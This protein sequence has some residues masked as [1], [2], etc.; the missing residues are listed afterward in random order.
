MDTKA[1]HERALRARRIERFTYGRWPADP[2]KMTK[3]LKELVA[4]A[5]TPQDHVQRE[6]GAVGVRISGLW[7]AKCVGP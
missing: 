2:A 5:A 7:D 3:A 6:A 1:I 4:L